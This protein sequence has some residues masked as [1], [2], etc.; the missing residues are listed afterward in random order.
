[1]SAERHDS[2][3]ELTPL[4]RRELLARLLRARSGR[5]RLS[6][7][8]E[9][10]WF[11]HQL[12]PDSAVY[13]VPAAVRLAG[14]LDVG[15]LERSLAEV[16]ARHEVLRTTFERHK[17]GPVPVVHETVEMTLRCE[18]LRDTAA[19]RR[20]QRALE[21]ANEE[22]RRPFDLEQGPLLRAVLLRL[23]EDDHLLVLTLHHIV[24]EGW[25]VA[26]LFGE[27][28][29]LYAAALE[30]ASSPLEALPIQYADYAR[31]QR[32]RSRG[33]ALEGE[34]DYW[35]RQLA[36]ELPVL[37]LPSD[38]VR[39]PVQTFGGAWRSRLL[40]PPL[41]H[42]AGALAQSQGATLFMVLLAAFQALLKRYT[43]HSD[44][45][46]GTPIAGRNRAEAEQLIGV[47]INTLVMRTDLSAD[48]TFEQLLER[49]RETA[50]GA[51]SHQEIPF[52]QVVEKLQPDR[53]LSHTPIF[54]VMFAMQNTPLPALQLAGL[55]PG[56]VLDPSQVHNG[57]TKVDLAMFVEETADGLEVGCEYSTDLFEAATIERLLG[58]YEV[59]LA[60]AVEAPA[61]RVSCLELLTEAERRQLLVDWNDTA[62]PYP[63]RA[64][65]ELFEQQA[66]ERPE[67]VAVVCGDT[68][69][70]YAELD[71]QANKLAR[72]LVES[73]VG[74]ESRVGIY[75]ERS[76]GLL[77][78]LLAVLKAGGAYLPLDPAYPRRRLAFMLEDAGAE[79][80]LTREALLDRA[81]RDR[82]PR[83]LPRPRSR[84]LGRA[85]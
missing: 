66:A 7:S 40:A 16:V 22:A 57:T 27:L 24:A 13:N 80:V 61:C 2:E 53:H 46:V 23:D 56:R 62:A 34:L 15:A 32:E 25:S 54:Q 71:R 1:M 78:S 82:R 19:T 79:V 64:V 21:R 58:H 8:Q 68:T 70:S 42:A 5:G 38:R 43:G 47:F 59:L 76:P 85:E 31:W 48:P 67:A 14:P 72:C 50:V 17:E 63:D 81:A 26:L 33:A 49:V 74:G 44:I 11:L 20:E 28:E 83:P 10:L 73:G 36:G 4:Q 30:G 84:R 3:S 60:A 12:V 52:E 39:P 65:H 18:D 6:Y 37:E 35:R 69:L 45:L 9:R 41:R 55:E 77:V 29:R 75:V 51:F